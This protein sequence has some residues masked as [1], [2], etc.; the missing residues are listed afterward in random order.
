MFILTELLPNER[1]HIIF[2]SKH[3]F[4]TRRLPNDRVIIVSC[5]MCLL[6]KFPTSLG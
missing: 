3:L 6:I 4:E 5:K 2:Y 1:K